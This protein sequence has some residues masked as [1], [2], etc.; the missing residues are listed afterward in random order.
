MKIVFVAVSLLFAMPVHAQKVYKCTDAG[1]HT[2]FSQYECDKDAKAIM[3]LPKSTASP[4]TTSDK[5]LKDIASEADHSGC[6]IDAEKLATYPSTVKIDQARAEI[7]AL[8]D[9]THV[10]TRVENE[11]WRQGTENKIVGLRQ[12][13]SQEEARN[14]IVRAESDKRVQAALSECDKKKM[15]RDAKSQ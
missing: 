14:D 8:E 2:V 1:G 15:E 4:T 12:L 3:D 9:E 6:R 10:G 5:A 13:I 7:A 11:V